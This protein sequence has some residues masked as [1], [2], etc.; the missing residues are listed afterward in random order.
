MA[1]RNSRDHPS[2]THRSNAPGTDGARRNGSDSTHHTAR[3]A[4]QQDPSKLVRD[5]GNRPTYL[6]LA[7]LLLAVA[8][9]ALLFLI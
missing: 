2:D 8:I 3:D 6:I 5:E 1:E 4:T 9:L 7:A